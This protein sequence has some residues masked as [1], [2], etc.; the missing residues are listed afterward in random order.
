MCKEAPLVKYDGRYRYSGD[1]TI[2]YLITKY[3]FK[4]LKTTTSFI[5]N[6]TIFW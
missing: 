3:G 1:N 5:T 2:K 4:E 6:Q